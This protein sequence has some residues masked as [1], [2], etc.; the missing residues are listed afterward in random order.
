MVMMLPNPHGGARAPSLHALPDLAAPYTASPGR[1]RLQL[2]H[3][4]GVYVAALDVPLARRGAL[5]AW[6]PALRVWRAVGVRRA[7]AVKPR[8]QRVQQR[9]ERRHAA[10]RLVVRLACGQWLCSVSSAVLGR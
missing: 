10:Q 6:A 9:R 7:A 8:Q 3:V 2:P 4:L 5:A 1:A